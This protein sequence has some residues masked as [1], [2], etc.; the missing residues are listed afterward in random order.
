LTGRE[1]NGVP[2]VVHRLPLTALKPDDLI[3][4]GRHVAD[5]TLRSRLKAAAGSAE[6]KAFIQA[7]VR[8]SQTD[9]LFAGIRRVRVVEPLSVIP[10]K[11][12]NGRAYKAYKGDS[13]F[14]YDVWELT[15]GKWMSEVISM[16]DAHQPGWLSGIRQQHHNARKVLS[17]HRDDVLAIE[18]GAGRELMRVVKFSESQFVLAPPNEGGALKARDADKGDPFKYVYPSPGTLKN[19]GARQVRIDELGRVQDPGPRSGP[20]VRSAG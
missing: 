2:I 9:P 5:E 13:N 3:D 11:D 14:R 17:L 12:R 15:D 7:L 6:G 18:R 1:E 19:W 8:F 20:L 10:I 16:F 4:G